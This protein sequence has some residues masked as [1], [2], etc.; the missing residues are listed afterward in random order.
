M[1]NSN[2]NYNKGSLAGFVYLV[3]G[4]CVEVQ[5]KADCGA[6]M[7]ILLNSFNSCVINHDGCWVRIVTLIAENKFFSFPTIDE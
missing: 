4:V 7:F 5:L 3:S 6:W 1:T 2:Y